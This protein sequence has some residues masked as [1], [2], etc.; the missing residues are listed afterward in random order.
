MV[1]QMGLGNG[2]GEKAKGL[3]LEIGKPVCDRCGSDC[4]V[5]G[6]LHRASGSKHFWREEIGAFR[7]GGQDQAACLLYQIQAPVTANDFLETKEI[8]WLLQARIAV[9]AFRHLKIRRLES[10]QDD[11]IYLLL[12]MIIEPIQHGEAVATR[13]A[14]VEQAEQGIWVLFAIRIH[15]A[16]GKIIDDLVAIAG[17]LNRV[18]DAADPEKQFDHFEV[19]AIV[20]S[21]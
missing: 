1:L 14:E 7:F 8:E 11:D 4:R 3:A 6:R 19:R 13:H 15:S 17:G 12:R 21:N 5:S 10:G 16:A 9:V 2:E 18:V 20:V